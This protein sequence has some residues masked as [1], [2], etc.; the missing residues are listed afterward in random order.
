MNI[1]ER[2]EIS[3]HQRLLNYR[4]RNLKTDGRLNVV[5]NWPYLNFYYLKNYC[6]K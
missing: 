6:L 2:A 4:M 5:C 3:I 1:R